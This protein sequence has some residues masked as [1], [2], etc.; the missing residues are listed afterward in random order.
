MVEQLNR[1]IE[2]LK[3]LTVMTKNVGRM[4]GFVFVMMATNV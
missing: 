2:Y 4:R 3:Q 1:S